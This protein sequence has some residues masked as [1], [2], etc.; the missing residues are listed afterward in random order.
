MYN[1]IFADCESSS[2]AFPTAIACGTFH[3]CALL[4]SGGV[5]CW[6]LNYYGQVGTGNIS[7]IVGPTAVKLNAGCGYSRNTFGLN[8]HTK[9][10]S[11]AIQK[12]S[13]RASIS[14]CCQR[15]SCWKVS[16][17]ILMHRKADSKALCLHYFWNVLYLC[18]RHFFF[19]SS[20]A[21]AE[22]HAVAVAAGANH[23]CALLY[24]GNVMCWG[25]N[26]YGQL[27]IENI[28][29]LLWPNTT[30]DLGTCNRVCQC[31]HPGHYCQCCVTRMLI[32]CICVHFEIKLFFLKL[33]TYV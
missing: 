22:S 33:W 11:Q 15:S 20:H 25:L 2:V 7:D 12:A 4:N 10:D 23:S 5:M 9:A 27:G 1:Q 19:W 8:M 21:F 24:N 31:L 32:T 3:T 17:I 14:L 30:V 13:L 28:S 6:G 16:Y 29:Q 18:S 26:S